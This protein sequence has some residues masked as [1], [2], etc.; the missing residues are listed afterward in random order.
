MHG[1]T[2]DH[3][4]FNAQAEA[5][6]PSHRVLVWDTRG[7]GRSK[8]IGEGFTLDICAADLIAV[9]D[10]EGMDTAVVGGQSW[11]GYIAQRVY[12]VAP[13]RVRAVV[14]IG[15]TPLAKA[16]S[17]FDVLALRSSLPMFKLWPYRHLVKMIADNTARTAAVKEYAFDAASRLTRAEFLTVWRAVTRAVDRHGD[18]EHRF[19]VPLLLLHG[20]NDR[21]GSIRRDMPGW[22]ESEPTATFHIIPAAGHSA[23]QDNAEATNRYLLDFLAGI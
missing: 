8:P 13:E 15:S 9:L 17:W 4:M 16:Y 22:A 10:A 5:L 18:P 14:V 19:E 11:G 3:R 2:Q 1:A 6:V 12:A 23:N 20:E 21:T 7:H